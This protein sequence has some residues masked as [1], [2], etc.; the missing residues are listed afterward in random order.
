MNKK[1]APSPI[2]SVH[3]RNCPC[4]FHESSTNDGSVSEEIVESSFKEW[5]T[6]IE[7]TTLCY[8]PGAAESMVIYGD[9]FNRRQL[10]HPTLFYNELVEWSSVLVKKRMRFYDEC[11]CAFLL[12]LRRTPPFDRHRY[13]RRLLLKTY[14]RETGFPRFKTWFTFILSA[15][16][17]DEEGEGLKKIKYTT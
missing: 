14:L 17:T 6:R 8:I 2:K 10:F 3:R 15:I 11:S 13:L 9:L 5:K 12:S 4:G 7:Q 16:R 1:R